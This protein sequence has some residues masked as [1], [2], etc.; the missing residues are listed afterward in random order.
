MSSKKQTASTDTSVGI[1]GIKIPS[2]NTIPSTVA[3]QWPSKQPSTF[4]GRSHLKRKSEKQKAPLASGGIP[5]VRSVATDPLT[6]SF[7]IYFLYFSSVR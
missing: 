3:K 1:T 4:C 5:T 6:N 7:L 2:H